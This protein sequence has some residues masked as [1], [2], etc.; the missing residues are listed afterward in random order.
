MVFRGE[1]HFCIPTHEHSQTTP[2]GQTNPCFVVHYRHRQQFN[3]NVWAGTVDDHWVARQFLSHQ[4][5]RNRYPHIVL[6][7]LLLLL[8]AGSVADRGRMWACTMVFWHV[9]DVPNKSYSDKQPGRQS[10][11]RSH[12]N[13][14]DTN[15][16]VHFNDLQ[17]C[18]SNLKRSST[19]LS[20]RGYLATSWT[21]IG[22]CCIASNRVGRAR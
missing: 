5:K 12:F 14:L 20:H 8:E 19:R 16:R 10:I 21:T 13:P 3:S 11:S 7:V 9:L 6:L 1:E 18:S 15:L 17:T 2:L 4:L 22:D